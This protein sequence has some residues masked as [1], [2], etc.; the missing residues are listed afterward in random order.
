[1][2]YVCIFNFPHRFACFS[3]NFMTVTKKSS[4]KKRKIPIKL[5]AL[6]TIVEHYG[7]V[8]GLCNITTEAAR[9]FSLCLTL[10]NFDSQCYL[11][12]GRTQYIVRVAKL[13]LFSIEQIAFIHCS[14]VAAVFSAVCTSVPTKVLFIKSCEGIFF[15]EIESEVWDGLDMLVSLSRGNLFT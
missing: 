10:S 15:Y 3:A 5:H 7:M 6:C 13:I 14:V 11:L 12:C 2:K 4:S 1:M 8:C 9:S